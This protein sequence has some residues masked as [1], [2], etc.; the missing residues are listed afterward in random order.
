MDSICGALSST[1]WYSTSFVTT[2]QV[3][4]RPSKILAP[5][6]MLFATSSVVSNWSAAN[7]ALG[8]TIAAATASMTRRRRRTGRRAAARASRSSVVDC[9][10]AAPRRRSSG[11]SSVIA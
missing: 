6:G 5:A 10:S 2:E 1:Q 8:S 3:A 4:W 7:A 11:E 9:S